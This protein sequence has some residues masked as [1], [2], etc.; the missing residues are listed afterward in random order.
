MGRRGAERSID[1]SLRG[2]ER[3][4]LSDCLVGAWVET[5][6][7]GSD[8]LPTEPRA[9]GRTVTVSPGDLTEAI[10]TIILIGDVGSDD[11][12]I[13]SA[14]EKTDAFRAGVLGGLDACPLDR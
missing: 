3:A 2:E 9:E 11:N 1:S 7:P 12:V 5:V 13:G 14:F 8:G 10:Q 6:I 4:L